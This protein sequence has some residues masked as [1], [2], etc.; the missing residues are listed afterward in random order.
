MQELHEKQGRMKRMVWCFGFTTGI[1]FKK[2]T[3]FCF[4]F[5]V[6]LFYFF[7]LSIC[8]TRITADLNKKPV[9]YEYNALCLTCNK[10][11]IECK[12][13]MKR[14]DAW[15]GWYAVSALQQGLCLKKILVFHFL[16]LSL[17]FFFFG[18]TACK[19]RNR[20]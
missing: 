12:N 5:L 20:A 1:V 15:N 10:S 7:G 13:R 2:N 4:S 8:K 3:C 9:T 17:C 16:S 14:R 6:F 18:L 11:R 19:T